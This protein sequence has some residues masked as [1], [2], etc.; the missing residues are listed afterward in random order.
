MSNTHVDVLIIGAGLSGIGAACHLKQK[1]P[2]KQIAILERRQNIGGTWDLFR[3]PG[4]RSDSDMFTLGYSFKPWKGDKVLADGP[5]IKNYVTEAADEFGVTPN[6]HF[7]LKV[8]SAEWTTENNRW[9]VTA[10]EEATG[11]TKTFT[12][13]FLLGCTGY[14]NYD[15]GYTPDFPGI[16][17][18]KGE[19]VHPQKWDE[20]IDYT[21]KRVVV[22]GSG[23]TAI[24]LVP[25][26]S[27][28]AKHVTMLQR[29]PTYIASVPS[30]DPVSTQLKK[31]LPDSVVYT[32]GRV[33]NIGL[34]RLIF[35]LSKQRPETI[36]RL[37]L[38][39]T[40]RRMGPDF[41]MK[42]FTPSYN[43]WDQRL[44][45]VPDSDLFKVLKKG[46][47]SIVTDHIDQFTEKGIQLKSG[48]TLEADMVV[49]ATGLELL[50][51]GG[52]AMK[53]DGKEMGVNESMSY[54]G[55]MISNIPNMAMVFGYTNASW[56]LKADLASEYVCRL[57]NYMDEKGFGRVVPR[58]DG[59]EV[60]K[61]PLLDL[62]AGYVKRA[63]DRL[64]KQGSEAPWN[65]FNN[66]LKDL[67][68]LKYGKIED[69]A[70][71][72]GAPKP[73]VR[74][75]LIGRVTAPLRAVMG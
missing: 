12:A 5:A 25:A 59:V 75:S 48:E 64:P 69:K 45:V 1:C 44:C 23:A 74:K 39:A 26:M 47:A 36:K 7:G 17:K 33:R 66:Y 72:F 6:I 71:E 54:K 13:G 57:L 62:E 58:N 10:L 38:T 30:V 73:P 21:D 16:S 60:T 61:A 34:Q 49:T 55:V 24:T 3:Y 8:I 15:T 20:S 52:I 51:M 40:K 11:K 65:I 27:D 67:P 9:T 43:P 35:K 41:D 37:L 32:M 70:L 31:F 29:S 42:H 56:T 22:I 63:A 19:V 46:K 2:T 4:I 28:K 14:Y 50:I 18:F 53:V 68:V